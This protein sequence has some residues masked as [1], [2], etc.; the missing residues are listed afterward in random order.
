MKLLTHR[1]QRLSEAQMY[2][3]GT[4]RRRTR[5]ETPSASGGQASGY[6]A[7]EPI[8]LRIAAAQLAE[9]GEIRELA[10]VTAKTPEAL[11]RVPL[12]TGLRDGDLIDLEDGRQI[13]ILTDSV[14]GSFDPDE[15]A[16]IAHLN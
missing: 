11:I 12:G 9:I 8:S 14:P 1:G 15:R 7:G 4:L 6:A 2:L 3:S 10:V 16:L 5:S 13:E